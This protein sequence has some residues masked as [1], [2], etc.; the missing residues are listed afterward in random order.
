MRGRAAIHSHKQ[1]IEDVF[2]RS[3]TLADD[4][5]ILADYAKYLCVLVSGFIEKSLSAIALEHARRAGAP[6]LQ[7]FVEANTSRFNNANTEKVLQFLGSFDS[8]WRRKLEPIIVDQYKSAFDS[9]VDLRNQIAH[10]VS[11]E[12]TY[13]RIKNYFDV[14]T[15]A[16]E[17]IEQECI[18]DK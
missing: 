2:T 15:E 9:I 7:R 1:R 6:S 13:V 5:E 10:G 11:V 17:I 18:P 16:I 3:K 4:P 8:D 12:I 14:I